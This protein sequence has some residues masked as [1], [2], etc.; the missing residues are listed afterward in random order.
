MQY[1]VIF[2]LARRVSSS[3]RRRLFLVIGLLQVVV[4]ALLVSNYG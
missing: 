2:E 3:M 4:A 1:F